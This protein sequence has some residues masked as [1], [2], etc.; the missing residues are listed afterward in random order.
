MKEYPLAKSQKSIGNQAFLPKITS[1][2]LI[3]KM[4]N[5]GSCCAASEEKNPADHTDTSFAPKYQRKQVNVWEATRLQAV[6]RGYLERRS[7]RDE[8]RTRVT[9][10]EVV[11]EIR[12]PEARNASIEA[13]ER[14]YGDFRYD[15]PVKEQ[16]KV[17]V[18]G[19]TQVENGAIYTGEWNDAGER[20]G[21]GSQTWQDGSK[22]EGYWQHDKANGKGR[23]IHADGEVYMGDWVN[24]KAQGVGV[25]VHTDMSKYEGGWKE[26]KQHGEGIETW[27]DGSRYEGGYVDGKKEGF[28]FFKWKDGSEYRGQFQD[29]NMQGTGR[30]Q[31]S[32]GRIYDGQWKLN[33]MDGK[34]VFIWPDGR[35]YVGEYVEDR[36]QGQGIFTWPDGRRYEG[37]WADGKQ[38][39]SGVYKD[40]AGE[41]RNSEWSHGR[42]VRDKSG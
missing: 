7:M 11:K 31:W 14:Y 35:K 5:S 34:G 27:A 15:S 23:L 19:P 22:Y 6:L 36:K 10:I 24:D 20:H 4:G 2:E 16:C 39:G 17:V 32:D 28:G 3:C 26:D 9:E 41:E 18:K 12:K 42:K 37:Q 21:K 1:F 33:K 38:H 30:Y 40:S 25:Y 8:Y 13:V 29:N